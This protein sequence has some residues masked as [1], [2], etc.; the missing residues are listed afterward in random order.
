MDL[1]TE[2]SAHFS[3]VIYDGPFSFASILE[4]C[5]TKTVAGADI[6]A[7]KV[8]IQTYSLIVETLSQLT[9]SRGPLPVPTAPCIATF[10]WIPTSILGFALPRLVSLYHR[11]HAAIAV[12]PYINVMMSFLF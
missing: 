4:I 6:P 3:G 8:K 9:E 7:Y 5:A 12:Q 11:H 1:T 10:I 2:L